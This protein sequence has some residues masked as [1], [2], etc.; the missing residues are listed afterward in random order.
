[1]ADN[2]SMRQRGVLCLSL[3]SAQGEGEWCI[4]HETVSKSVYFIQKLNVFYILTKC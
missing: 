1:M 4:C 2:Y 3:D